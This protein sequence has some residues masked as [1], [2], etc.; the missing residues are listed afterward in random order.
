[1][2]EPSHKKNSNPLDDL[3]DDLSATLHGK[4][5]DIHNT[6]VGTVEG[7][8]VSMAK[9]AARVVR[10]SAMNM[11]DSAA[12]LIQASS[13]EM[14]SSASVA[15][16]SKEA[17]LNDA[18]ASFVGASSVTVQNATVGLLIAGRVEGNVK[19]VLTPLGA[20]AFGA[21]VGIAMTV[22][23]E[24]FYRLRRARS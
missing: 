9:S 21:G 12:M 22:L 1:M 8:R 24:V 20:L 10:A 23:K 16:F 19:A 11:D 15:V 14:E 3:A 5:V 6:S 7:G 17:T 2:S 18:N 4:N 13:L